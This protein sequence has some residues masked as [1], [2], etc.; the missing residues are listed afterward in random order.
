MES[1]SMYLLVDSAILPEVFAKVI[2]AKKLLSSGKAK[3][4]N[5]AVSAAGL[6]RSAFYKYRDHVFPF[7]ETSRGR[8]ITLYFA[9]ED[10]SG[11]LSRIINKIAEARAN[12]ITI[13]Q[14]VPIN[15]LAD[16]TISISTAGMTMDLDKLMEGIAEIEGVRKQQILA[17]D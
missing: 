13:N 6:S 1:K 10:F 4:V 14:N 17:R 8:V 3:T 2:E 7:Y 9:V 16:V 12:I 11:I 15:G 5:D